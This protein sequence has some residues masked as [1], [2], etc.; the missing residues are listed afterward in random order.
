MSDTTLRDQLW[1]TTKKSILGFADLTPESVIAG[2]APDCL[3]SIFPT[4]MGHPTRNNQQWSEFIMELKKTMPDVHYIIPDDFEPV[5]DER[6]KAVFTYV[7]S[8]A[9]TT[10]GPYANQYFMVFRMNDDGT[11]IKEIIEYVDTLVAEEL[12][13]KSGIQEMVSSNNDGRPSWVG[14]SVESCST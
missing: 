6:K 3:H 1:E 11:Q 9:N 4:T 10:I 8:A 13:T 2:R 5:I 7:K 14:H 12:V